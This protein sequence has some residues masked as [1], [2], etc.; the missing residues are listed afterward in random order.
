MTKIAFVFPG[1][2]SQSVGMLDGFAGNASVA[3]V[4]ARA[5]AALGE[6]LG[7]LMAN[8]PAEQLN[9]TTYTQPV[10]LTAGVAAYAACRRR[11]GR[12]PRS[13]P[14]TAWANTRRWSPPARSRWKMR[15]GWS[16]SVP[17]PCSPRFPW[18]RAAWRPSWA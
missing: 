4:V 8:G 1:Q 14:G 13:S 12:L 3:D 6:D 7:G 10:M 5:G 2:G 15:C 17:T 16:A 11:A 9:L 18:G